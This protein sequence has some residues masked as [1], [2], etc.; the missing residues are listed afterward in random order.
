[1]QVKPWPIILFFALVKFL[2]PFLGIDP[3][4]ELHR[5]EYLYLAGSAHPAWGYLEAPPLLAW[6]GRISL[7]MGGSL[8]S[9]RFWGAFF[10]ALHMILV[11]KIV[12]TLGGRS[13]AVLLACLAFLCGSALRMHIL[14]Q[15]NMLDIFAWSLVCY[16]F[17]QLIQTNRA[18]YLYFLSLSLVF[19]WYGKYSIVF[20][21]GPMALA[22]VLDT[23]LRHYFTGRHLYFAAAVFL[24]LISPNLYWQISHG[25]P[26]MRHMKLLNQ[27]LLV[28]VS[29]SQFVKEQ[30]LFNLPALVVWGAGLSWLIAY[31]SARPY[32]PILVIYAGIIGLLLAANGK[33]Y[34]SMG[35]YPVLVAFGG[36]AI[37]KWTGTAGTGKTVI[38]WVIPFLVGA[39]TLPFLPVL[40]PL[41]KP[42]TLAEYYRITG[43]E[44]T[45]VL[46][47]ERGDQHELPQD[48]AD[49]LGWKQLAGKTAK[50]YYQLPDSMRS[51]TLIFGDQY[52]F[53]GAVQFFGRPLGLPEIYSDD[54][55]FLFWLPQKIGAR[56]V[57]LLDHRPRDPDDPVFSRFDQ[58][59]MMD[60][61]TTPLARERGVKIMLYPNADDSFAIISQ[62][63]IQTLKQPYRME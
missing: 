49:M 44:K 6:L 19:G 27:Q 16:F 60:S 53:A 9:V 18:R 1:M 57:I 10:G 39:L 34:Y 55:S 63:A 29:R 22:F 43:M 23:R 41:A 24:L 20:I 8:E 52:A 58:P 40:L 31:R 48:F 13:Y 5:D 14:F 25:F 36:M 35:I 37:E 42:A 47:W 56:H 62:K 28:H 7:W 26:V 46:T 4:Y 51:K 21:I 30:L 15:P 32:R 17:I 11:G 2:V 3:V 12:L 33:G 38:R 59:V 61:M 54:A 45:G 50:V